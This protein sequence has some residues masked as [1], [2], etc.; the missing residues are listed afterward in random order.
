[1]SPLT[2]PPPPTP[3]P[4]TLLNRSNP[5]T[6]L[7]PPIANLPSASTNHE[8]LTTSPST[9]SAKIL[10]RLGPSAKFKRKPIPLPLAVVTTPTTP[11]NVRVSPVLPSPESTTPMNS[12]IN[13]PPILQQ[14]LS[15]SSTGLKSI[16]KQ[17]SLSNSSSSPPPLP[18]SSNDRKSSTSYV[19]PLASNETRSHV[20][21]PP[22]TNRSASTDSTVKRTPP[23][24]PTS[25][26]EKK[27]P[28]NQQDTSVFTNDIDERHSDEKKSTW[29]TPPTKQQ[30]SSNEGNNVKKLMLDKI[31]KKSTATPSTPSTPTTPKSAT[32]ETT[33]PPVKTV[34]P[35][36]KPP[37][38]SSLGSKFPQL[39]LERLDP[40][41][42]KTTS[43]TSGKAN[44]KPIKLKRSNIFQSD[45]DTEKKSTI[46]DVQKMKKS[47]LNNEITKR[48]QQHQQKPI[49]T[50]KTINTKPTA[51]PAAKIVRKQSTTETHS[52]ASDTDEKKAEQTA[53]TTN[54]EEEQESSD[55]DNKKVKK[56]T[57]TV[58]KNKTKSSQ[59]SANW[60]DLPKATSMY[61]RIKKRARSE[62]TR[63]RYELVM[64][65]RLQILLKEL[66]SS[67]Y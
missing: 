59:N 38:A 43:D 4:S 50:K 8:P 19:S 42:L 49:L 53:T 60:R 29:R 22:V 6:L 35:T 18:S 3:P 20:Q 66:F 67:L 21:T 17:R 10:E 39:T 1:M 25:I 54:S 51:K 52:S 7:S 14:Q 16:L 34:K 9:S 28:I 26:N 13:S 45:S 56:R 24:T 2:C 48:K 47:L 61:D 33:K 11:T 37:V 57:K 44:N 40:K 23:T 58:S 27:K 62:Q 12:G 32:A 63:N 31:P 41:S 36:T 15:N 64:I 30:A 55:D 46:N 65:S 5:M